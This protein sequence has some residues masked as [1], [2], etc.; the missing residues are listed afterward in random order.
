MKILVIEDDRK[1]ADYLR[2]GLSESGFLVD[3]A[4]NGADALHLATTGDYDLI[5]LDV[6]LPQW[7]GWS[8]L[9]KLRSNGK[10]MPVLFLSACDAVSDRVKGLELG[11]DDYLVKPFTFSEFRARVKTLLRRAPGRQ[12]ETLCIADLKL[13]LGQQ[14]VTRGGQRIHLTAKEFGLLSLMMR[15]AGEILPRTLIAEQ[16]WDMNFDSD[17]NVV[18]VA[19]RRL[20]G[21]VDDPYD[22]KLI[23]SVR[24]MGYVLETR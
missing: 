20:R 2:K 9:S 13:D 7:D 11:A 8:I 15:R 17:T 23:H 4:D 18:D 12:T 22:L 24:G 10:Q 6:M 3:V 14:K 1:T 19:I 5:T 21:K 16:V